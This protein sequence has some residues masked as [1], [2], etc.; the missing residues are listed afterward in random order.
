M[1]FNFT[2]MI[3]IAMAIL[4]CVMVSFILR[5]REHAL[6]HIQLI[7]GM[8][9]PAYWISNCI[10][11]ILKVYIPVLLI[12]GLT[13]AFNINY[14]GVWALLLLYPLA[15]VPFSYMTTF[16]FINDTKAQIM[17]FFVHFASCAIMGVVIY[18]L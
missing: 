6:K 4:P 3:S 12:I 5:E 2:F 15:I 13:F 10:A 11:D 7:S 17:T 1:A 18:F 16:L 14:Q 8:N 9:L